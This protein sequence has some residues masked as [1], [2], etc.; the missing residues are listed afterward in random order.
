MLIGTVPAGAT[1][2]SL[3][4]AAVPI[5]A[6]GRFL[7]AFGRDHG[8]AAT[9]IASFAD[10]GAVVDRLTVSPRDWRIESLPIP[11]GTSPS[12]EFLARRAGETARIK[13]ARVRAEAVQSDGWRQQFQWPVIGRISGL[14]GAQRV[15]QGEKG[16]YHSG[17]DV[18]QPTGTPVRAPADG[19]VLLAARDDLFSLEGHLLMIGHGMGLDSAFLHL[20]QI[21]V[22]PGQVVRQGQVIGRVG[23]TGRAT[24]PH[25]HWA[26]TWRGERIDPLLVTPPMASPISGG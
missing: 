24:G 26:L 25:L 16:A 23:M 13:E 17:L 18:A 5:A 1:G 22:V 19:V 3:D 6:D 4:G 10:G 7:I 11:R 21:D 9:L 8:A 12:P 15:Y 14:F 20:S 2:L